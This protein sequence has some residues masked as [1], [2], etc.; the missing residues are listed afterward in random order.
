MTV[1]ELQIEFFA[2]DPYEHIM[3][4][5]QKRAQPIIEA[6]QTVAQSSL[7]NKAHKV[8]EFAL[9]DLVDDVPPE[10]TE[11]EFDELLTG[12]QWE[13]NHADP[14]LRRD[15]IQTLR[16][17]LRGKSANSFNSMYNARVNSL[18]KSKFAEEVRCARVGNLC[19]HIVALGREAYESAMAR[20][21]DFMMLMEF[22]SDAGMYSALG[23]NPV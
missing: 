16:N 4:P 3:K 10:L 19:E 7:P 12:L 15:A 6:R 2:L 1:D 9:P 21:P 13:R 23:R 17:N 11:A 8:H 18:R 14:K 22:I 20:D 5:I